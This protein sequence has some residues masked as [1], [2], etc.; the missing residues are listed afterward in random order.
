M[1]LNKKIEKAI[2]INIYQSYKNTKK[3][4]IDNLKEKYD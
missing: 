1:K 4:K 3:K 2:D